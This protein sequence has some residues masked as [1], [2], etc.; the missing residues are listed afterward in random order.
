[1]PIHDWTR[2]P[3]GLFHDFHQSWSIRIKDALNA[4]LLSKGVAA[5]VEQRAGPRE[6]DVLAIER[7]TKQPGNLDGGVA[8]MPPPPRG[9]SA[10]PPGRFIPSGPTAS[11]SSTILGGS[12]P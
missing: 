4:G 2:V 5:L 1:M 10:A 11:S 6:P 12:S 9:S 7:R 8:I 3:A